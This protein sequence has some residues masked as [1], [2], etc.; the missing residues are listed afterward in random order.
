M[1]QRGD[2]AA[3]RRVRLSKTYTYLQ[4]FV[5]EYQVIKDIS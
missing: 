5:L 1:F 3:H 4:G 2:Q